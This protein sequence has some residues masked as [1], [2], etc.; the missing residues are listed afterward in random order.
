MKIDQVKREQ[1]KPG[2]VDEVLGD[3][4]P[5]YWRPKSLSEWVKL[6]KTS[7][8]IETWKQQQNQERALRRV[9]GFWVFV[10]ISFQILA[11]FGL[12]LF[13]GLDYIDIDENVAK[14]FIPSAIAEVFGM[15][16]LVVKYLFSRPTK[17][18]PTM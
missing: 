17:N 10:I 12:V 9:I 5:D 14:I 18:K 3:T 8:E 7:I 1:V 4:E 11:L 13:E 2:F 6:K 16:F 15:G